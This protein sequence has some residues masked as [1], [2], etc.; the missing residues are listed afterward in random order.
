MY[1]RFK[2]ENHH[3]RDLRLCLFVAAEIARVHCQDKSK[4]NYAEPPDY[5][6]NW[7]GYLGGGDWFKHILLVK[8]G[9]D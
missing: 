4:I 2:L 8:R 7:Q 3:H 6:Q 5:L 1:V 9:G